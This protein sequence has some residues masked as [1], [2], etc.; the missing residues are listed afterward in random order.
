MTVCKACGQELKGPPRVTPRTKQVVE[1]LLEGCNNTEIGERLG[2]SPRTVKSHLHS[3][4]LRFGVRD[5]VKRI[6]LARLLQEKE[7]I[8][9]GRGSS[10]QQKNG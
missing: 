9:T 3:L 1:L 5:G 2:I 7:W 4:Y 8:A 10:R 6:K